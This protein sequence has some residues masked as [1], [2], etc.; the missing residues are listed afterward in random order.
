M[1]LWTADTDGSLKWYVVADLEGKGTKLIPPSRAILS[2]RQV[3]KQT[4]DGL[5]TGCTRGGREGRAY[6]KG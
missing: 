3:W 2:D 5:T 6:A 4:G 1:L